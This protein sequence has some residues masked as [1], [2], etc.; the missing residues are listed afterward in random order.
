MPS[1]EVGRILIFELSIH[2][3]DIAVASAQEFRISDKLSLLVLELV[4]DRGTEMQAAKLFGQ[5]VITPNSS[6]VFE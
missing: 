5:P 1:R 3:W 6:T 4:A 2:A